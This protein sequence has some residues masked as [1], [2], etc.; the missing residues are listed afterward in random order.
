MES[1][2]KKYP[3]QI[4]KKVGRPVRITPPSHCLPFTDGRKTIGVGE[5]IGTVYALLGEGIIPSTICAQLFVDNLFDH[6]K[7]TAE[8]LSTFK[9][10]TN[11]Y[12]FI[13][14]SINKKFNLIKDFVEVLKIYK[15]MKSSEDRFGM[16]INMLNMLKLTK[17]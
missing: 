10:Y 8:V 16:E 11:V 17:I 7:Y 14:K 13:K 12:N 6:G 15:Y 2:L 1:F 5:S 4:L 9:I 3:C